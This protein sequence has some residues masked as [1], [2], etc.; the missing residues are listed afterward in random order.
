VLVGAAIAVHGIRRAVARRLLIALMLTLNFWYAGGCLEQR[1]EE[2]RFT[3]LQAAAQYLDASLEAGD[4]AVVASPL[5]FPILT[6]YS[7]HEQQLK[8]VYEGDH[9]A[10]INV[11]TPLH[12]SD[13]LT[14]P[15]LT[16]VSPAGRVWTVSQFALRRTPAA[17]TIAPPSEWRTVERRTF[18]DEGHTPQ[19][20]VIRRWES[21]VPAD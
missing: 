6:F 13:C 14:P 7:D 19:V 18:R 1:R 10:D 12:D 8:C 15:T 5:A 2:A 20:A 21:G 11:G 9:R 16:E 4:I 17:A 3:G